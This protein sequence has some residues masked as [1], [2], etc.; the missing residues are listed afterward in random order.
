MTRRRPWLSVLAVVVALASVYAVRIARWSPLPVEGPQPADGYVRVAG[1]VHVH[2]THSDGG[3]SPGEVIAAAREAGLQ[4]LVITDHDTLEAKRIEGYHDNVLVLVGAEISTD[5]GHVLGL[6]ISDPV[7]RFSGDVRDALMDV[8]D[9][10]GVAFAAHPVTPRTE[11]EWAGW[12]EPGNWG[13]ELLNGDSQWRVAGPLRLARAAAMYP[14]NARYALLSILTPP[15]DTLE[16]W[17]TLLQEREVP[18]IAGLDA[19]AR[20]PIAGQTGFDFPSYRS[21]F[22]VMRNH[23]LLDRAPS[24]D[25]ERDT[26]ALLDALSRG[27]GY[28]GI[29]ALAPASG[30]SFVV[31]Q[32]GHQWTMGDIV[33]YGAGIT[34]RAGGAMPSGALVRLIHDGRVIEERPGAVV[35]ENV[36]PGVYRV[37]VFVPGWE[38]PWVLSNPIYVF[39][40][41]T[42]SRRRA[43]AAW[44][45]EP[46]PPRPVL[47]ID[48]FED[49]SSFDAIA[50]AAS[51]A[52][53][54]AFDPHG[55][56]DRGGA[57]RLTFHLAEPSTDRPHPFSALVRAA[58]QDLSGY[59]GLVLRIRA[60]GEYR[61]WA[62]VRD[63][64]PASM[65]EGTESWFASVRA[66]PEWRTVAL[67]FARLRSINR[68]TDGRLD[69]AR[70]RAIVFVLDAAAVKP[71]TR[72]TIWIDEVG[73]Y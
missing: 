64:N 16:R 11:F 55:G 47:V 53:Q 28:V 59:T 18:G 50:D 49:G 39:D 40:D 5:A 8:R 56:V 19:H 46:P 25:V 35:R 32:E 54:P 43:Q 57:A 1:V 10:G 24:G 60:D 70:V 27:R 21:L 7:Y 45:D 51:F 14:L 23:V 15:R 67:P 66:S 9:L 69:L 44:P 22:T 48:T 33:P 58:D 36:E 3:G 38:P 26:A 62:Q 61:I 52:E 12:S 2:T 13:I 72:G 34:L 41:L 29:D 37:E 42:A 4:F 71:G 20:V 30:F 17:D 63:E 65:D 31:E 68:N 6:G 73:V